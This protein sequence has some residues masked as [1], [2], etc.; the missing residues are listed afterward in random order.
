MRCYDWHGKRKCACKSYD[1]LEAIIYS[2][3]FMIA[4][5]CIPHIWVNVKCESSLTLSMQLRLERTWIRGSAL[6]IAIAFGIVVMN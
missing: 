2:V 1:Q 4:V 6:E 3:V 5:I